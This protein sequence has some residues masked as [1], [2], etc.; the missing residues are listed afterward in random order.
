MRPLC[1]VLI[2]Q[3]SRMTGNGTVVDFGAVFTEIVGPA[4]EDA[5][6]DAVAAPGAMAGGI[7]HDAMVE[8]LLLCEC[9]VGD[10]TVADPGVFY[11]LGVRHALRPQG[12]IPIHAAGHRPAVEVALL[13]PLPYRLGPDGRPAD[14]AADRKAL[15]ARLAPGRREETAGPAFHLARDVPTPD[16]KRLKTDL[17]RERVG[18][19]ARLRDE[20][21]VARR[22]GREAVRAVEQRLGRIADAD[23]G[24]VV[25]LLLS[26]RAVKAWD[27]MIRLYGRM[28]APLAGTV[29]VREQYAFALNR[30]G[31]GQEAERELLDL[32]R[33]NG[34]SSETWGL[35]G[36]VYKDRWDAARRD[37]DVDRGESF[38]TQA[39]EAYRQGFEA[40]WRDA[41]PGVNAVTL[42]ELRTP[43]D[44][45]QATLLPVVRYAV[46]RRVAGG[47]PDYWDY[48]T[49]LEL[50]V[51]A[52]DEAAARG[53]LADA[54]SRIREPW[55]PETTA[56]NLRLIREAR[57][58][59][60]ECRP[61]LREI[62][63]LLETKTGSASAP[64]NELPQASR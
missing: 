41:Y 1:V 33:T 2:P 8:R 25:D 11:G 27:E 17:F 16:I 57:T 23:I 7:V 10:L 28:S 12:T 61:W 59:R 62:E 36:R 55:E 38:L 4:I 54:L 58:A 20:L 51:L 48:A 64:D 5:G 34:P 43:P 39:V 37:G 26:Y 42:M 19:S 44:P 31:R 24:S 29:L 18:G 40:D 15:A 30:A 50:A 46:D 13:H 9:V 53:A 32:I 6:L 49:L 52:G 60:G 14:A 63:H 21:A 56:N 22:Q 47:T 45:R 35:L 3:G